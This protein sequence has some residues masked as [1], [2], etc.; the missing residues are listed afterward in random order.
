M[1]TTAQNTK[2]IF[3]QWIL[4]P[5]VVLTIALGW[6]YPI[7]G[8]SAPIVMITGVI[9]GFINSRYVCGNICPR[10]SFF[11]RILSRFSRNISTPVFMKHIAFRI[12]IFV[13]LMGFMA[14]QILQKPYEWHHWGLVFW[15]MCVITTTIGIVLGLV[16]HQRAWCIFCPIG[17]VQNILGENAH[18][19]QIDSN[20]C[21]ECR[22]CEKTCLMHIP[23]LSYKQKGVVT[24]NDCVKCSECI[25]VCPVNALSFKT[26][27]DKNITCKK[28]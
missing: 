12:F 18:H 19:L 5:I 23:I 15:R 16:F 27:S 9:G 11:D 17:T 21:K 26:K 7:L 14:F 10:G 6:K 2:R 3:L 13:V 25:F 1:K 28:S 22:V 8:F 4:L 24:D 20:L